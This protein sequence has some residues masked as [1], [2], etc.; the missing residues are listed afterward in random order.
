MNFKS[1]YIPVSSISALFLLILA[2]SLQVTNQKKNFFNDITRQL[3]LAN[4]KLGSIVGNSRDTLSFRQKEDALKMMQL[5][6][7]EKN[8]NCVKLSSKKFFIVYPPEVFCDSLLNDQS[9]GEH[10]KNYSNIKLDLFISSEGLNQSI[11]KT[12]INNILWGLAVLVVIQVLFKLYLIR[13]MNA[14]AEESKRNIRNFVITNPT[15]TMLT[16][17]DGLIVDISD[18]CAA[19]SPELI[20]LFRR[21]SSDSF[22]YGIHEVFEPA[23]TIRIEY[24]LD[25]ASGLE[26]GKSISLQSIQ[27]HAPVDF[28]QRP[29]ILLKISSINYGDEKY[30]LFTLNDITYLVFQRELLDIS[31]RKDSLTQ[32]FSRQY[33]MEEFRDGKRDE[34]FAM[35]VL[36]VD[37][38]KSINHRYGHDAGDK[39]LCMIANKLVN[40]VG[41]S[42]TLARLYGDSFALLI[43]C[44][45]RDELEVISERLNSESALCIELYGK[46]VSCTY[47]FGSTLLDIH[48]NLDA[49]IAHAE[50]ALIMARQ[51]SMNSYVISEYYP[52]C[53]GKHVLKNGTRLEVVEKAYLNNEISLWLQPIFDCKCGNIIGAESLIRWYSNDGQQFAPDIYLEALYEL[54]RLEDSLVNHYK[55]AYDLFDNLEGAFNGWISYNIN[56]WDLDDKL[57]PRLLS[58]VESFKNYSSLSIVLELSESTLQEFSDL[59]VVLDRVEIL[60]AKGALLALDDF[61]V[62]SSNFLSLSKLS[63]DMV[64]LDK[65]LTTDVLDNPKNQSIIK[66]LSDLSASLG[67]TLIAEGV[68]NIK[69]AHFLGNLGVSVHQGY[70]YGKAMSP[71]KFKKLCS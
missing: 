71:D 10:L 26:T 45:T 55:I 41:S 11:R 16:S 69:S 52:S 30:Y 4:E 29:N 64:K 54:S 12:F 14:K 53:D 25:N 61:G 19:I 21:N 34:C 9:I 70:Y 32:A 31:L 58:L 24:A 65:F 1:T 63:V 57:F 22:E 36:D 47:S 23:S 44:E 62:L 27:L 66:S 46:D 42:G 48:D 38:F 43:P 8:I 59:A 2:S 67:F 60:K 15:P 17:P 7:H 28:K 50:D 51:K 35:I 20:Q 6:T 5:I 3:E 68:E 33:L 13:L 39:T 56:S 40:F 37:S 49:Q 18:S